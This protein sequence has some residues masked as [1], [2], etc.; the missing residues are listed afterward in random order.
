M[1]F[2]KFKSVKLKVTIPLFLTLCLLLLTLGGLIYYN[3][4]RFLSTELEEKVASAIKQIQGFYTDAIGNEQS[5]REL[6][7][8]NLIALTRSVAQQIKLNPDLLDTYALKTLKSSLKVVEEIH[9][10]DANGVITHST[11]EDLIGFD[12]NSSE[13]SKPFMAGA[14][15]PT[16]ELAQEPANRGLDNQL[17]QYAGV[18]RLDQPGI[19]QIGIL[20]D[21]IARVISANNLSN[22]LERTKFD[23][24]MPWIANEE[25]L[26]TYH[27][28]PNFA[29][30]SL[31]DLGIASKIIDQIEGT[32]RYTTPEGSRRYVSFLNMGGEYL[33][34]TGDLDKA[35]APAQKI[36]VFFIF[37]GLIGLAAS[38]VILYLFV[39]VIIG[40]PILNLAQG[41][42]EIA[43]GDLT[44]TID[45][46]TTDEIGTLMTNFNNMTQSLRDLILKV[47]HTAQKVT[48]SSQELADITAETT[49][50]AAQVAATIEELAAT[51]STQAVNAEEGSNLIQSLTES[52][53]LI[54]DQMKDVMASVESAESM[55]T[56]GTQV[57]SNQVQ[58]M[59][60]SKAATL[61]AA[62]IIE[63]LAEQAQNVA[64]IV[65]TIQA[66]SNQTNLLALNAAI[67]AARA[68]E[69]GLG[70]S[71]VADEVR[72]LAEETA[73]AT[74]KVGQIIEFIQSNVKAAVAEMSVAEKAVQAQ[75]QAVINT[76]QAFNQ[77]SSMVNVISEKVTTAVQEN[78]ANV[79]NLD[80]MLSTIENLSASAEEAAAGSEE[81]SASTQ[82]QTAAME[83]IAH[84]A[85][86]LAHLSNELVTMVARFKTS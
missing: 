33:G 72:G 18:G 16:F 42:T 64:K 30:R 73:Q 78:E 52:I 28:D 51:A 44:R 61:K 1:F 23:S 24:A 10:I 26:I 46:R 31:E 85:E 76:T 14:N 74:T 70:F 77:I 21:T 54:M 55:S 50:S 68:G 13:Q 82:Q 53:R 84:A 37:I 25:G 7:N 81:A 71:V 69:H 57:V 60:D 19:I 49:Q 22:I 20:P 66:I 86:G 58:K 47:T 29:G 62:Q 11:H 80:L 67:E 75:E 27:Q 34:V 39:H 4:V 32:F 48:S 9:V 6:N 3:Q 56:K 15:D 83:Q 5:I 12:L 45:I 40:R 41:T 63:G 36:L 65:D 38:S 35:L 17:F 2:D 59:Q 79:R 8:Q 43:A